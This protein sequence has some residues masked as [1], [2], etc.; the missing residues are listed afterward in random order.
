MSRPFIG[1]N[2]EI[3]RNLFSTIHTQYPAFENS[4]TKNSKASFRA[5]K[6]YPNTYVGT[7]YKMY[8]AFGL[9]IAC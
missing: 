7:S 2:Q 5:N 3:N 9:C 4:R 8:G 1:F 6:G